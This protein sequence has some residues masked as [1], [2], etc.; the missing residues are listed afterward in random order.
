MDRDVKASD[1]ITHT[2]AEVAEQLREFKAEILPMAS[3]TVSYGD[4][5]VFRIDPVRHDKDRITNAPKVSLFRVT[6]GKIR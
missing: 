3:N 1:T 2:F 5:P 4:V 6:P